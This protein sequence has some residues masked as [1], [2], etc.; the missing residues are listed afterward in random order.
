VPNSVASLQRRQRFNRILWQRY[1][2]HGRQKH[3]VRGP[4][5][6]LAHASFALGRVS[7]PAVV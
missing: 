5:A 6:I 1:A 7:L 2:N 4:A 3:Q